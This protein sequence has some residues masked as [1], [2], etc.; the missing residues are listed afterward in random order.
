V[1]L[2][3]GE[4]KA[5][6]YRVLNPQGRVPTLVLD[7]GTV[8]TQ[9]PAIIEYLE[10][11]FP[12]P[13]LLPGDPVARAKVRAVAAII[14]CDIHPLHNVGPLNHLRS[15]FGRS[16]PEVAGWIAT[17]I[18]QGLAAVEALSGDSSFCFG[19][20]PGL[21]D[22]YLVPQLYAARRFDVPLGGY[23]RILRVGRLAA[24][25]PAFPSGRG[26]LGTEL[27]IDERMVVR[28]ILVELA[29]RRQEIKKS[30]FIAVAG[31]VADEVAAKDFIATQSDPAANH[32]CWAWRVGQNYRFNDD[33]EPGGTA[34]KPIL[35][36][37]DGQGVDRVAVVVTRWFGGILL[38]S[39]GLIRAYGGTAALCLREAEK[40]ALIETVSGTVT[41][42]FSD[43]ALVQARLI[44]VTGA[45]MGVQA[46]TDSGAI[47]SVSA[48]KPKA[49]GVE[50]LLTDLTSGRS[51]IRWNE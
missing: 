49:G 1:H 13:P 43:L 48:P 37:I 17:W 21:A 11:V 7:D 39:G 45:Q 18:G 47:L 8:L 33:G 16:E 50:R 32:N 20:Q 40:A 31:P 30:R 51:V 3:R 6:A 42:G 29:I 19:P 36:A 2:V 24:E 46:F 28:L 38:G 44:A 4:Q 41:C 23:R 25:H 12:K 14:G 10:E 22:V 35:A 26:R 34:G 27:M 15:V 9:S 5:E